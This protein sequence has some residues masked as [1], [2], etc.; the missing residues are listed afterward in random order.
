MPQLDKVT[1]ISQIF[2]LI[3]MFVVFYGLIIRVYLPKLAKIMKLRL[4]TLTYAKGYV[5]HLKK[6][7]EFIL[8]DEDLVKSLNV[9]SKFIGQEIDNA[10][11]WYTTTQHDLL[12]NS[13]HNLNVAYITSVSVSPAL[14]YV[15]KNRWCRN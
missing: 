10:N 8:D 6:E 3:V 15:I 2:W 9:G 13:L 7:E 14:E 5:N 4:S 11:K 1:F 12:L